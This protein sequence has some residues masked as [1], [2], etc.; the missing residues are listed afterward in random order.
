MGT[1]NENKGLQWKY[2]GLQ[3]KS[4][5]SNEN[6]G[7]CIATKLWGLKNENKGLR[8]RRNKFNNQFM[9]VSIKNLGV[10]NKIKSGLK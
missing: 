9:G 3:H 10:S 7:V 1:S 4:W 5:V 8:L 2:Q 6:L